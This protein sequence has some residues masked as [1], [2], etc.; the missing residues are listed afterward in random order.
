METFGNKNSAISAQNYAEKGTDDNTCQNDDTDEEISDGEHNFQQ[1]ETFGNKNYAN[2]GTEFC[3]KNCDYITSYKSKFNVHIN[4]KKH[5]SRQNIKNYAQNGTDYICSQ[6]GYITYKKSSL[7][8]HFKSK[9]HLINVTYNGN[10]KF[11]VNDNNNSINNSIN[12]NNNINNDTDTDNGH[13]IFVCEYCDKQYTVRSGLWK[14]KLKCLNKNKNINTDNAVSSISQNTLITPELIIELIKNNTELKNIILGQ[15]TTISEQNNTINNLVSNGINN[16]NNSELHNN[17][18]NKTFNLSFFLN[19]TCK[20]AMNIKDFVNSMDIPFNDFT[21]V[22]DVGYVEGLSNIIV[23]SLNNLDIT[24]RPIHCTDKK[25]EIMYVKDNGVWE[26]EDE[27]NTK[28]R[29]M[30][31]HVAH[32]NAGLLLTFREK[33]PDCNK[34][35]SKYSNQYTKL[36]IESMGGSGD[37]DKEKENKII[38]NISKSVTISKS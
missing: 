19:E 8:N 3:C 21:K 1:K 29:L 11:I 28:L 18:H 16:I 24:K 22:G 20:D 13:K 9:K 4:T 15:N 31:K 34:S 17:S 37:N 30:V 27:N 23:K 6:C 2:F 25:R 36:T 7:I 33:Y 26:K 35:S 14:H 12:L 32:K 5:K 10:N 38:K